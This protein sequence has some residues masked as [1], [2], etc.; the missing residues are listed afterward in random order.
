MA[1]L[2]WPYPSRV[3]IQ[4]DAH[5]VVVAQQGYRLAQ[6]LGFSEVERAALSTAI[7]EVARNIV[8]Y[9]GAGEIEV[10][11]I[12]DDVATEIIVIA[13]DQGPGIADLDLAMQDGYSTGRSLGLGLPGAR[14]LMDEFEIIS[15][16]G[17]G[18][19]IIMKK[20]RHDR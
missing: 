6:Q 13:E 11:Y 1:D 3:R 10:N 20:I 8:K 14:R 18:T 7:M 4:D 19:T 12:R 5:A 9:A 2:T 16:P 17:K 15:E